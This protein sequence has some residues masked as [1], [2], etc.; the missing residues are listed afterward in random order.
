MSKT[1][2]GL[3]DPDFS[4]QLRMQSAL[5]GMPLALVECIAEARHI[6]TTTVF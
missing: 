5:E 6:P 4:V 1:Q 3:A 2:E